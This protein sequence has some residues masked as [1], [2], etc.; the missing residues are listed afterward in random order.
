MTS[1]SPDARSRHSRTR[2]NTRYESAS[3]RGRAHLAT[4]NGVLSMTRETPPA[5]VTP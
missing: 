4:G 5:Q 1:H 2:E 3:D